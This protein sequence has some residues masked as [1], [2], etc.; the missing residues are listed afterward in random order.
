MTILDIKKMIFEKVKYIFKSD[1]PIYKSEE[2][3]NKNIILH[4]VDN[5]PL[6]QDSKYSRRKVLCEF[7]KNTHGQADTCDI[8]IDS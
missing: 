1:C 3:L 7:C 5:L 2:E 4:I 6:Y 8:K